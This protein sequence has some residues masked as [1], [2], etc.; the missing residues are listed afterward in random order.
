MSDKDSHPAQADTARPVYP[1]ILDKSHVTSPH[2]DWRAQILPAEAPDEDE[3]GMGTPKG[4]YAPEPAASSE[5]PKTEE[6]QTRV[7]TAPEAPATKDS[8]VPKAPSGPGSR[9][10]SAPKTTPGKNVPPAA[11]PTP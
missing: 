11:P 5:S 1:V 8:G 7:T 2:T 10:S 3:G 6:P 4:F 9:P